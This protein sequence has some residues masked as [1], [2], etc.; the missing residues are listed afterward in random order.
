MIEQII[1]DGCAI[2]LHP[3]DDGTY[4]WMCPNCKREDLELSAETNLADYIPNITCSNCG[5]QFGVDKR[6]LNTQTSEPIGEE[7]IAGVEELLAKAQDY[8]LPDDDKIA[9]ALEY[10]KRSPELLRRLVE[11]VERLQGEMNAVARITNDKGIKR[12]VK[13]AHTRVSKEITAFA[14]RGGKYA[15]G[16]AS[17]GYNGG[18]R[19]ALSDVLL[20]LNGTCPNRNDWWSRQRKDH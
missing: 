20:A 9:A 16:L 13:Q 3:N 8:D 4:H 17:E 7:L 19:D 10:A 1:N 12:Q 5:F 14:A 6:Y 15:S 2:I 18:Y 11:E